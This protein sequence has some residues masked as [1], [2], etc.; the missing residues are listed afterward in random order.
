MIDHDGEMVCDVCKVRTCH[1]TLAK[2]EAGRPNDECQ[3]CYWTRVL[4]VGGLKARL[5]AVSAQCVEAE[6]LRSVC[7]ADNYRLSGEARVSA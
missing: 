6:R 2:P 4:D 3:Q 7:L 5:E 1:L